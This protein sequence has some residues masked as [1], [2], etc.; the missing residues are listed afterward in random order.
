LQDWI[1]PTWLQ[2]TNPASVIS[3]QR[4]QSSHFVRASLDVHTDVCV[5]Q[6]K[7]Y[8]W[9]VHILAMETSLQVSDG[10]NFDELVPYVPSHYGPIYGCPDGG[11]YASGGS[12]RN[13]PTCSLEFH[14][15]SHVIP[16]T[17]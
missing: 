6:L 2:L 15:R 1:N 10:Y 4:L 8:W 11:T 3:I 5:A 14:G 13:P 9:A 16:D 12:V 17:P 7:M